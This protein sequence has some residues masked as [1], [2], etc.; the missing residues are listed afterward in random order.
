MSPTSVAAV[1]LGG[2][3]LGAAG[4]ALL[5]AR[6]TAREWAALRSEIRELHAGLERVVRVA[7]RV[8]HSTERTPEELRRLGERVARV[9]HALALPEWSDE[10]NEPVVRPRPS[11]VRLLA[12]AAGVGEGLRYLRQGSASATPAPVATEG[13]DASPKDARGSLAAGRGPTAPEREPTG[14]AGRERGRT[15]ADV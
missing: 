7:E 14:V 12:L 10:A 8:A 6:A 15:W 4:V 9:E 3:A 11:I 2:L 5:L 1:V 13:G